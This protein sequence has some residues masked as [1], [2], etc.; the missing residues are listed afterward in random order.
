MRIPIVAAAALL[1]PA[2]AAGAQPYVAEVPPPV[3]PR[4]VAATYL[5]HAIIAVYPVENNLV[6][7]LI[8]DR[9]RAKAPSPILV[10]R[11]S[12][13]P[14]RC[15]VPLQVF[16]DGSRVARFRVPAKPA[17]VRVEL[18]PEHEYPDAD[19]SNDVWVRKP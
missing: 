16:L 8:H 2:L 3:A 11:A 1:L 4:G 19:R 6:E 12:G 17:I 10:T 18:D 7:I 5:D 9:G 14:T 15:E 13:E